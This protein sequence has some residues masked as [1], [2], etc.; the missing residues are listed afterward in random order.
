METNTELNKLMTY[1]WVRDVSKRVFDAELDPEI[2]EDEIARLFNKMN[3]INCQN[4]TYNEI[5]KIV[6]NRLGKKYVE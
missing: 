2:A 3:I 4:F 5:T 6:T 1:I